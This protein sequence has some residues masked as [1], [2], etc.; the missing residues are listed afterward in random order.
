MA[1]DG[2][3]PQLAVAQQL[4]HGILRRDEAPVMAAVRV[5]PSACST[6][7]SRVMVRSPSFFRSNTGAQAAADQPLDLLGAAALL[8]AR[9]LAVAARVRGARQ[10]AVFGGHPALAA[11]ALVR[12]HLLLDGGGAQHA[13]VAEL[14]EHRAL[15]MHGEA[16]G[17]AHGTQLVGGALAASDE[18]VMG[19]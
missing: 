7:Q 19:E 16:A 8:A 6:S 18:W 5:P 10:H 1:G 4:G 9:R 14:D 12:R 11:A 3:F 17:D 15:G 2:R 13:R